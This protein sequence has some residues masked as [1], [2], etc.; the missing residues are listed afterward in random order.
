MDRYG[1]TLL[2]N[3]SEA[4]DG[5]PLTFAWRTAERHM[6]S[7]QAGGSVLR[8][9]RGA[10]GRHPGRRTDRNA[11]AKVH[12]APE[13]GKR[14]ADITDRPIDIGAFKRCDGSRAKE[15]GRI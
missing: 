10:A 14:A 3:D 8:V 12:R 11:E 1:Q 2:Q 5:R 9:Q 6:Q 13:V 4:V 7:R 15:T